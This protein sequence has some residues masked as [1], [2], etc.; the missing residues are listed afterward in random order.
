MTPGIIRLF[1]RLRDPLRETLEPAEPRVRKSV[2][3]AIG[4]PARRIDVPVWLHRYRA[5]LGFAAT[6]SQIA[7]EFLARVELCAG[8][9]VPVDLAH[10]T[11]SER[12]QVQIIAMHMAAI[13]LA[14]PPITNFDLSIAG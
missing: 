9:L 5:S 13:D 14:P 7:D 6:V 12:E 4:G 3:W 11:K 1:P 8:R 2:A 10:K